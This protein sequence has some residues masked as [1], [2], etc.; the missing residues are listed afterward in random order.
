MF[1]I[2]LLS[3]HFAALLGLIAW[4]PAHLRQAEVARRRCLDAATHTPSHASLPAVGI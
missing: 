4:D 2:I 3:L 1:I